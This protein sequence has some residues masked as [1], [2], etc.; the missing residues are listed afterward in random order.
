MPEAEASAAEGRIVHIAAQDDLKLV[1]R[2]FGR[3]DPRRLPVLCLAGLSRNS[4]DFIALGQY[5]A[6]R[7][8]DSRFVAALDSRGRGLSASDRRWQNYSPL[9]ETQDAMAAAAAL[10]IE[11]S[12]I[13]GTSRGGI[14]AMIIGALR[15]G[16][17]AGVV[18]NDIGPVIE[19]T[20][21]ARIKKYLSNRRLP[22]SWQE[23]IGAV[24][25][26]N[27]AHFPGLDEADWQAM[28]EATFMETNGALAPRFDPNLLKMVDG[29]DLETALPVLW[30]QFD[31]LAGVPVLSIR[32][33]N[34]DILRPETVDAMEL[35]HPHFERLT[36]P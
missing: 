17:L 35:R 5:L 12:V 9:V 21:L 26:I 7:A 27:Q 19:G 28:A 31:S 33:E 13:V 1:A 36:V 16:L 24:K 3:P 25:R 4:R 15:P 2:L 29:I 10:G 30:S 11:K 23:A 20:G 34:S 6:D 14:L 22:Q 18:L 8:G 32:G